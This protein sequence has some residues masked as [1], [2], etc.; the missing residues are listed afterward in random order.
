M[1]RL[2]FITCES[3]QHVKIQD[4]NPVILTPTYSF[5]SY[6]TTQ[7]ELSNETHY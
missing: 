2:D 1:F 5:D 3:Q 6:R 4:P 7:S